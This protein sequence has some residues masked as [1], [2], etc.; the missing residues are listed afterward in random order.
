MT[1]V[2]GN[3]SVQV[4]AGT[5]PPPNPPTIVPSTGALPSEVEGVAVDST[6][7]A[8]VSGGVPPYTFQV[9]GLPAGVNA[10][11][12]VNA[13]GSSDISLSGTPAIGDA[14]GGDGAGNY[15]VVIAV[16]DSAPV[17]AAA[18]TAKRVLNVGK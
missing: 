12:T 1:Q 17:A 6:P 7:F 2:I 18:A 15:A 11:E 14:T 10:N 5:P 13:D 4:T 9:A 3:F 16:N 8:H